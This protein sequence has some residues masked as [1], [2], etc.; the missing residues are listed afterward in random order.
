MAVTLV[1]RCSPID[2][3]ILITGPKAKVLSF[4]RP[5]QLTAKPVTG[6]QTHMG[7]GF[8]NRGNVLVGLYGMWQDAEKRPKD[9]KYW[10][11]RCDH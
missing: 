11:R 2:L 6:Q 1:A 8:W 7:A 5:G 10:E 4:A 3:Q 9:G